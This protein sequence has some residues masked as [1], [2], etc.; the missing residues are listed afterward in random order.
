MTTK[1]QKHG[2]K[3]SKMNS[4]N[5][6]FTYVWAP[7]PKKKPS[8]WPAHGSEGLKTAIC[9]GVTSPWCG[10][11]TEVVFL[12]Q[13]SGWTWFYPLEIGVLLCYEAKVR[14]EMLPVNFPEWI[15]SPQNQGWK[16][17]KSL[18][19]SLFRASLSRSARSFPQQRRMASSPNLGGFIEGFTRQ[20]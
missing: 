15:D 3:K 16:R 8:W 18:P 14:P 20:I 5:D 6:A 17:M 13:R 1:H 10:K 9:F 11:L 7:W 4:F 19:V 2:E 12:D